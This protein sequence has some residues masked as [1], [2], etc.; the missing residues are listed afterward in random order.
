MTLD[1][2][3]R[4]V[5]GDGLEVVLIVVGSVLL[6]RLLRWVI[7]RTVSLVD[8]REEAADDFSASENRKH[9]RAVAQVLGWCGVVLAL[10]DPDGRV[11][12]TLG[13][14]RRHAPHQRPADVDAGRPQALPELVAAV[15]PGCST[16][17]PRPARVDGHEALREHDELGPAVTRVADQLDH[18]VGGGLGVQHDGCGLDRRHPDGSERR[19]PV[20]GRSDGGGGRFGH[21]GGVDGRPSTPAG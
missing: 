9:E 18:A 2:V 11:D 4:W 20:E 3:S 17:R 14:G 8:R 13:A 7:D 21:H 16:G 10:V 6:A 19:H 1:D 15:C 12:P 5:R